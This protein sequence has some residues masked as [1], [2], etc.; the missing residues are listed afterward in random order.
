M[1]SN[2]SSGL[3]VTVLNDFLKPEETCTKPSIFTKPQ[4]CFRSLFL[5]I[6]KDK[7]IP[8]QLANKFGKTIE[9]DD[10]GLQN[11]LMNVETTQVAKI[12]L[13]DCLACRFETKNS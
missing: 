5:I 9:Y 6:N 12:S 7:N 10:A 3:R 8:E 13:A 1:D 2:F 4:V 11:N